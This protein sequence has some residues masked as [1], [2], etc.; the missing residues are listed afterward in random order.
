M[1][2]MFEG[3]NSL[4]YLDLSNFNTSQVMSFNGMFNGCES[5]ES[6]NLSNFDTSN[7]YNM[8]EM[9]EGC[10]SLT[11][12]DLSNFNT[13]QVYDFSQMFKDCSSLQ[14]LNL[15]NFDTSQAEEISGIFTN[16]SSL[17]ILD[18]SNFNLENVYDDNLFS[19]LNNLKYI[20]L[21]SFKGNLPN[22]DHTITY[23]AD[24][25]NNKDEIISNLSKTNSTNDCS[26]TCFQEANIYIEDEDKCILNCKKINKYFNYNRTE[27]IEEIPDGYFLNDSNLNTSDKCH[28]N[29]KKNKKKEEG[30]NNNCLECI[31]NY[32][33]MNDSI[34]NT[35][36]YEI[37]KIYYYY[38]SKNEYNCCNE[39]PTN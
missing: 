35:T 21:L 31:S 13:S 18:I 25:S 11:S 7:A 4:T 33:F 38:D 34:Y 32:T 24:N 28:S 17:A 16:C 5:L 20:N 37:C 1:S 6:L 29:C 2:S 3:C 36:C 8:T 27:C 12:L 14:S 22:I 23:C 10:N 15:S 26:N 30:N 39:C 19:N 9:F